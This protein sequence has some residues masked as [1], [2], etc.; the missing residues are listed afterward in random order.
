MLLY[1]TVPGHE[2]FLECSGDCMLGVMA[3]AQNQNQGFAYFGLLQSSL[4]HTVPQLA[5]CP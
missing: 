3:Q 1:I 5:Q 4:T 2:V